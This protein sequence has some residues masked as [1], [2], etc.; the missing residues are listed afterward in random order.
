MR[1]LRLATFASVFVRFFLA[2]KA[3]FNF[4]APSPAEV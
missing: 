2:A 4:Q 1:F 3:D